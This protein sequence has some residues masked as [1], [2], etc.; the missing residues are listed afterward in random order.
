MALDSNNPYSYH[1]WYIFALFWI[2]IIVDGVKRII[3]MLT[4]EGTKA[5]NAILWFVLLIEIIIFFFVG[6]HNQTLFFIKKNIVFY[7]LGVIIGRTKLDFRSN[8]YVVFGI[9]GILFTSL[10]VIF[11]KN[12][13][14]SNSNLIVTLKDLHILIGIPSMIFFLVYISRKI[15]RTWI[16]NG[17]QSLG[18]YSYNVYLLHQ[19]FCCAFLG[20]ILLKWIGG[21]LLGDMLSIAICVIMSTVF[22]IIIIRMMYKLGL[23]RLMKL[24]LNIS[25]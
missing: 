25:I 8:F 9:V 18:R 14:I 1:L 5:Y 12:E 17:L 22:P 2:Q 20:I 21:T 10:N 16:S 7:T 15:E 6:T 24:L 19:P 23:G 3:H 13:M 11:V 4:K